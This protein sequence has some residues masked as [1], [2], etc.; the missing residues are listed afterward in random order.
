MKGQQLSLDDQAAQMAEQMLAKGA[1]NDLPQGRLGSEGAEG[2]FTPQ[3]EGEAINADAEKAELSKMGD[4][5]ADGMEMGKS[6]TAITAVAETEEPQVVEK[7][8]EPEAEEEEEEEEKE[9]K[10]DYK[11]YK[12]AKSDVELVDADTL[13]KSL[14]TLEAIAQGSTVQAPA[15]RREELGQKLAEGVLSKSEM[16]EL[17]ELMKA[18]VEAVEEA[19]AEEVPVEEPIAKAEPEVKAETTH[20]EVFAADEELQKGYEVSEFLER[21]SQV[22]ATALDQVQDSL[23]KSIETH[24]DRA[25]AFNT[26]LAKSLMGMVQLSQRQESLIKSLEERLGTVEN[27]PMPRRAVSRQTQVLNKSIDGE[28]GIGA[29]EGLQKADIMDSLE[30]MALRG[31]ETTAS[32]QRVDYA[33]ALVEHNGEITKSLYNDVAAWRAKNSGTVRV[34]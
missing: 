30:Q 25:T 29:D 14:E 9:E 20:Q 28:A 16:V 2:G 24:R 10:E 1:A 4:V 33:M 18:S 17:S 6:N 34:N 13:I 31:I 19:P 15:D 8:M 23:T 3:I 12:A 5:E 27:S 26:Q 32:G 22:T 21:H 11:K 7:A